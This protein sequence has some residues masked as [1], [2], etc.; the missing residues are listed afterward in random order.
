MVT[1]SQ[2]PFM[3][4]EVIIGICL[5]EA[6]TRVG[7]C[8]VSLT[9]PSHSAISPML[10]VSFGIRHSHTNIFGGGG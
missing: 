6:E 8:L 2:C 3:F 7:I 4:L 5:T 9:L 10:L 1:I